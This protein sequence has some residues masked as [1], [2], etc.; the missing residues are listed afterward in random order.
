MSSTPHW[1]TFTP[2]LTNIRS[3][4]LEHTYKVFQAFLKWAVRSQY[5]REI[6]ISPRTLDMVQVWIANHKDMR[7]VREF[8][9]T[10]Q[11]I[12][13]VLNEVK[14]KHYEITFLLWAYTGMRFNE[15]LARA[16]D[17]INIPSSTI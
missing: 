2:P 7:P 6:P 9:V 14:D 3:S 13:E 16:W 10:E 4:I 17:D 5:I 12:S 1:Y 8:E 15:A 11:V